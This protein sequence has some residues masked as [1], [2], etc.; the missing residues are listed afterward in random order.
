MRAW[1]MFLF[2]GERNTVG[3]WDLIWGWLTDPSPKAGHGAPAPDGGHTATMTDDAPEENAD[4]AAGEP[5]WYRPNDAVYTT[6]YHYPRPT[7]SSEALALENALAHQL[8]GHDLTLPPLPRVAEKVLKDLRSRKSSFNQIAR[9]VA[10]DQVIAG[11]VLRMAN[12]PLYRGRDKIQSLQPAVVR[13]GTNS[14]KTLMMHQS[15]RAVSAGF[16]GRTAHYAAAVWLN[17]QASAFVMRQLAPLRGIDVDDAFMIGLLHD[18]GNVVVLRQAAQHTKIADLQI[19]QEEFDYIC[20]EC[21]QEFGELIADAWALPEHLKTIISTHHT[22]PEPDNPLRTE[23]L[24]IHACD[25]IC[26]LLG[27]GPPQ[28]Y[29]LL[30]SRAVADLGLDDNRDFLDVLEVLPGEVD[31]LLDAL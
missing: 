25:M 7:L 17:S 10:E 13:L 27:Y 31:D 14:I 1:T 15:L 30:E 12:S 28:P 29:D 22:Y 9:H 11:A 26:A 4:E 18:I 16:K 3:L 5:P 24:L 21:H 8:D 23:I 6:L 2:E 20:H 19:S